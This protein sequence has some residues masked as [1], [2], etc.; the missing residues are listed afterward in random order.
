[1][2]FNFNPLITITP[3][4]EQGQM[5]V[6]F[7]SNSA[8]D[9]VRKPSFASVAMSQFKH[10]VFDCE[11]FTADSAKE[12]GDEKTFD[13]KVVL[14]NPLAGEPESKV[15][16][17]ILSLKLKAK[18]RAKKGSP[19]VFE[20]P[21]QQEVQGAIRQ[22]LARAAAAAMFQYAAQPI[23]VAPS[24]DEPVA[25]RGSR[26]VAK[27]SFVPSLSSANDDGLQKAGHFRRNL[28]MAAVAGPL[29]VLAI[30]GV[31]K[32]SK[33]ADP[34]QQ[35]VADAMAH[36]P[37]TANAQVDLVKQTLKEMNL[38]P[39]NGGDTGCLAQ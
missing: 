17:A 32:V 10:F 24:Q 8:L 27:R 30:I 31:A 35:A 6:V 16:L 11:G 5:L 26:Q 39:G 33:P 7:D 3:S 15:E 14:R 12:S 13:G 2:E 29:L 34:I 23:A 18:G 9:V 38:D 21:S 22:G 19:G 28:A 4:V 25:S 1:M 20:F 37:A 36:N